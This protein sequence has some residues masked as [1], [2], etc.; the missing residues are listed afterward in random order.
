MIRKYNRMKAR[1]EKLTQNLLYVKQLFCLLSC[2]I[3]A[4]AWLSFQDMLVYLK[5]LNAFYYGNSLF[6]AW[7]TVWLAKNFI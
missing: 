2:Y 4:T 6:S 7:M 1:K 3:N 5:V